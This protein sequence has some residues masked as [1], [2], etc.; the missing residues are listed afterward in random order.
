[1]NVR[2]LAQVGA[3]AAAL[4]IVAVIVAAAVPSYSPGGEPIGWTAGLIGV[5]HLGEVAAAVAVQR[6]GLA[7]TGGLARAGLALWIVGGLAYV[8]GGLMYLVGAE[9]SEVGFSVGALAS[10]IGL[11]LAG[12]AVLRTGAWP[13]PG[14]FLPLVIGVYV[15]AVMVPV[16]SATSA[17]LPVIGGWCALWLLLALGLLGS[18]RVHPSIRETS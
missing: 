1:M 9:P 17:A 13:G 12:I 18:A 2:T 8:A 16:L 7:G 11:V 10:G 14:R 5:L 4:Q 15:Y 6:S 3:A